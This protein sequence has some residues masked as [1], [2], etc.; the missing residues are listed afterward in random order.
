MDGSMARPTSTAEEHEEHNLAAQGLDHGEHHQDDLRR[1]ATDLEHQV[2]RLRLEA[3][4]RAHD[5]QAGQHGA[6]RSKLTKLDSY[7]TPDPEH[8][9]R[10]TVPDVK[11]ST[12]TPAE[13]LGAAPLAASGALPD[14]TP[15][16]PTEEAAAASPIDMNDSLTLSTTSPPLQAQDRGD[17]SNLERSLRAGQPHNLSDSPFLPPRHWVGGE[18]LRQRARRAGAHG[19]GPS[20]SDSDESDDPVPRR[21]GGGAGAGRG[22]GG[23]GGRQPP[24]LPDQDGDDDGNHD[25]PVQ[26][27][28]ATLGQAATPKQHETFFTDVT[29][30]LEIYAK[31]LQSTDRQLKALTLA[32][33]KAL[34]RQ[35]K[36]NQSVNF[37]SLLAEAN[38]DQETSD[39]TK[40]ITLLNKRIK[41][42]RKTQ[43]EAYLGIGRLC[44]DAYGAPAYSGKESSLAAVGEKHW[45]MP[46]HL[47]GRANPQIA[48]ALLV[49][50]GSLCQSHWR[51]CW[52]LIAV[53]TRM[54]K[55]VDDKLTP[56]KPDSV[57]NLR[58]KPGG[59]GMFAACPALAAVYRSQSRELATI[60]VLRDKKAM[61][62]TLELFVSS[63]SDDTSMINLK[64]EPGDALMSVYY[65]VAKHMRFRFMSRIK[66][67]DL[68]MYMSSHFG[69]G[70]IPD[71]IRKV[72]AFLPLA[73]IMK[74]KIPYSLTIGATASVLQNRGS[75]FI[76]PMQKYLTPPRW[77][78]DP[79][80]ALSA[81]DTFLGEVEHTHSLHGHRG[82]YQDSN[83]AQDQRGRKAWANL[84]KEV[85]V[86][87][88]SLPPEGAE[89]P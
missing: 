66:L 15:R 67:Q 30:Q 68:L 26:N 51:Q 84:A 72:R 2:D 20:G 44:A 22:P 46:Q 81:V 54:H 89:L 75:A 17:T 41:G 70:P 40:V 29:I 13:Q 18:D 45:K 10:T 4:E 25:D 11:G 36:E 82:S 57:S 52:A 78:S 63:N 37:D 39:A 59:R 64:S 60:M 69:R 56:W 73:R 14:L 19:D 23:R 83:S 77:V 38:E 3:E 61:D 79:N 12:A 48:E 1:Y 80:D 65:L 6:P 74:L 58:T 76:Y 62:S 5:E 8:V 47:L 9:M 27:E 7:H 53:I 24:R 85:S 16:Q 71:A 43:D 87:F 88:Y 33:R 50:V 86:S 21:G 28:V 34:E 42:V 49:Q 32:Q 31:N 35:A 55:D